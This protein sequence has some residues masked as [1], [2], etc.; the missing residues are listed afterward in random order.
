MRG[1][2]DAPGGDAPAAARRRRSRAPT[3]GRSTSDVAR[4]WGANLALRASTLAS[5]GAFDENAP[6]GAGDEEEWEERYLAAGGRIRYLATAALD[7]RRNAADSRLRALAIAAARRGA[8]ARRY[9]E[10]RGVAPPMRAELRTFAGC[11]WHALARR[12]ANGP[13]MAAHSARADRGGARS[14]AG[15]QPRAGGR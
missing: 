10:R 15:A 2:K 12:C 8:S 1:S 4:G 3:T 5:I 9:D 14:R 13:V 6:T 7:H 11:V